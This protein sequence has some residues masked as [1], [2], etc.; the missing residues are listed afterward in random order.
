MG[1]TR[2]RFAD[3]VVSR[4]QRQLLRNGRPL[5]LIPRYF[6]LLVLLVERRHTAVSRRDIFD[7]V[8]ADVIVS[9]GALSQAIRTLRRTLGDD[10]REP[11]YIRTVSR[12]GYSF[13][14]PDVAEE[15]DDQG[16]SPPRA[17][18]P[19]A[20]SA[21]DVP[22]TRDS[23]DEL[24]DRLVTAPG[25][26]APGDEDQR[27]AAERLHVLGTAIALERLTARPGHARALALMRDAR[28]DVPGAGDVPL[29]GQR[30]GLAAAWALVRLRAA[31]A[32]LI[33]ERKW[34]WAAVGAG[35]AGAL[36]GLVGG[37]LLVSAPTSTGSPTIVPVLAAIGAAAGALGATGVAVGIGG[38]EALAR[39]RRSAAIIAGGAVG[40]LLVALLAKAG[41]RWTLE[42]LFG[43]HLAMVSGGMEGLVLGGAA[44]I[45][46]AATTRR[47][48]GGMASPTGRQRWITALAVAGCCAGGGL[49]LALAGRP[50]VG[51]V[52]TAIALASQNSNISLTPLA[53]LIGHPSFGPA[54]RALMAVLESGCFGL[55]LAWGL[56]RRPRS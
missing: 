18:T 11:I 3:F 42:G 48:G 26:A 31:R 24:I 56:T 36:A 32:F 35:S 22:D 27:D 53:F 29:L 55:G 45:G 14:F 9:D 8:W 51:G 37:A 16:L 52:I 10:S 1:E 46:Y 12:H 17:P 38:A 49:L 19:P 47:P 21:A 28:W 30:E 2:F 34:A 33:V 23:L 43:F 13:V 20:T 6:D 41:V 54:M 7:R 44:A 39:S 15:S 25:A 5:P 4:S 40:G 50:L